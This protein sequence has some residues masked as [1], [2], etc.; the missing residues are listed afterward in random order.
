MIL[1]AFKNKGGR[2]LYLC[3]VKGVALVQFLLF[4]LAPR[5]Y[6]TETHRDTV[7]VDGHVLHIT[8]SVEIDTI[9]AK[10]EKSSF[11]SWMEDAEFRT[12]T[13]AGSEIGGDPVIDNYFYRVKSNYRFG[14]LG[15]DVS[16]PFKE[17]FQLFYTFGVSS[18]LA[19]NFKENEVDINAIGF[20]WENTELLQIIAVDDPL[21]NELDT[22]SVP[23][24]NNPLFKLSVGAEWR[25]VMRGARGWV[26]GGQIEWFPVKSDRAF[27]YSAPTNPKE[28]DDITSDSTFD[29]VRNETSSL[30]LRAYTS[31]SPWNFPW[32][33]RA[34]MCWSPNIIS[35][36]VVL[37]YMW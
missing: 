25:G 29:I 26:W 4:L 2:S 21:Q 37:G 16:H 34:E 3:I 8:A 9:K 7:V 11:W 18:S 32:F 22:L 24:N 36:S 31:W 15:L 35:S 23:I 20:I 30:Q 5:A 28:W 1:R 6:A 33:L 14:E 19:K 17:S 13:R 12:Y 27:L 10:I